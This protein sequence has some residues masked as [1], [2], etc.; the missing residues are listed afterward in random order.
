MIIREIKD[1]DSS[2]WLTFDYLNDY[3]DTRYWAVTNAPDKVKTLDEG[4]N[5]WLKKW[6]TMK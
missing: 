3:D 4:F 6:Q 2:F 5:K 1:C